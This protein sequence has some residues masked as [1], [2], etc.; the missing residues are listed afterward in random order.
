MIYI[1]HMYGAIV[2][3]MYKLKTR[4][5][6]MS[7]DHKIEWHDPRKKIWGF[8][9][10]QELPLSAFT[11]ALY[12]QEKC[13]DFL[14]S[15]HIPISND[16]VIKPG[17]GPHLDYM[18][19]LRVEE[20]TDRVLE[21]LGLAISYMAI[22][23]FKLSAY[24]HPLMQD[25]SLSEVEALAVEGRDNQSN[26]LW[27]SYR[28]PQKQDFFFDP[29]KNDDNT[30]VDTR[31]MRIMS[32]EEVFNLRSIGE[33]ELR[34]EKF[35]DPSQVI[36]QGF[37]IHM[38]YSKEDEPLALAVYDKFLSYLLVE[39]MRPTSTCFYKPR[40]NGPHILGGW[41]VKFEIS[42]STILEKIGIPIAWLM[43][44][45]QG[46]SVFMHPVSWHEGDHREELKAHKEYS[47]FLGQ[48]PELDLSFF[49]NK[50][51]GDLK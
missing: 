15:N 39:N 19:E 16:D 5:L 23:R 35:H 4:S 14:N 28:V 44:N 24:I 37:H 1:L 33:N 12:I 2:K 32:A 36:I 7:K 43:C 34:S 42:D 38:D 51:K 13:R 41:E 49:S 47:F 46:L 29:P 18:W 50:I 40:E 17:Y 21:K 31:S 22:N 27:F 11:K 10:H 3:L 48:M 6:V 45:R 26:A 8:H 30:I 9:V 25:R 20:A